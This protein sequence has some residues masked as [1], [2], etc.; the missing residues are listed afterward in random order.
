MLPQLKLPKSFIQ[1]KYLL[2]ISWAVIAEANLNIAKTEWR[3]NNVE[4]A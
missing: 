2:I 3:V 4:M 1:F